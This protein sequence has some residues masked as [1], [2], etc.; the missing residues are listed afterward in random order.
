MVDCYTARNAT[1]LMQVVD[2]AGLMQVVNK[3][4]QACWLQQVASSL[5]KSDLMQFDICSCCK[6]LKQLATSLLITKINK[7][8]RTT[9]SKSADKLQQICWQLVASLMT[10]TCSKSVHNLKQ[11]C[12]QRVTDLFSTS[13][14]K[15]C[16]RI[17][18]QLDAT[19]CNKP[20]ADL[21][22]LGRFWLCMSGTL[23]W[24]LLHEV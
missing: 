9:C 2:F 21:L 8:D 23:L 3:L 4:H 13:W 22:Q 7:F 14:S 17:W 20:A 1:D 19:N 18:Y 11:V 15:P 6:L 16:E 12:W 5:W 10:T 24:Q